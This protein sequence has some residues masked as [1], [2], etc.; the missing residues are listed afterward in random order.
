MCSRIWCTDLQFL[1]RLPIVHVN[2]ETRRLPWLL[3]NGFQTCLKVHCYYEQTI[4]ST[5]CHFL[6]MPVAVH[7]KT[8]SSRRLLACDR[9]NLQSSRPS[10]SNLFAELIYPLILSWA[11]WNPTP[12]LQLFPHVPW[13][14][15]VACTCSHP[16]PR[17]LRCSS[18]LKDDFHALTNILKWLSLSGLGHIVWLLCCYLLTI[19]RHMKRDRQ[20]DCWMETNLQDLSRSHLEVLG[21]QGP[22][23]EFWES[24]SDASW[25]WWPGLH[26][27][28]IKGYVWKLCSIREGLGF[29]IAL[30]KTYLWNESSILD[31]Q[32]EGWTS[33]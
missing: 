9:S 12:K 30:M 3:L 17:L 22:W 18:P 23:T 28:H 32:N 11:Y 1:L 20:P 7:R 27:S 5:C 2:E 24:F 25:V 21:H 33:Y 31:A 29:L 10:L 26:Q 4:R 14:L 16:R 13:G 15:S 8:T 6:Q 19:C